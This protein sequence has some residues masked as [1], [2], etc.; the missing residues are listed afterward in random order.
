MR[1]LVMLLGAVLLAAPEQGP[2][3]DYYPVQIGTRWHYRVEAADKQGQ[4]TMQVGKI[5]KIDDQVLARMESLTKGRVTGSEHI[6]SDATGIHRHRVNGLECTPPLCLLRYPVKDGESW[7]S[8]IRM[9]EEKAKVKCTVGKD[10]VE[11]PAGKYKAVTTRVELE[12]AGK[13]FVFVYW[14]VPGV[15]VVKQTGELG[16]LRMKLELEK[17]EAAG[18]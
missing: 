3:L 12:Q 11:V 13:K 16:D 2:V 14:F 15:G 4:M 6:R 18:K 8:E 9:G 7:E 17:F 5:E 10:E 1:S